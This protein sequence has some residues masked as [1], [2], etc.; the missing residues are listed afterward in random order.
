MLPR[1]TRER[2]RAHFFASLLTD[3]L[4]PSNWLLANPAALHRM[5]DTGGKNLVAGVQNLL[6]D[7]RHNNMLPSQVDRTPFQL[8]VNVAATP[9]RWST[10]RRCSSS[11]STRPAPPRF[12]PGPW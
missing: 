6:H 2:G 9:A 11:S 12:T 3:A 7:L 4:A 1:S 5:V 8:G 10:G